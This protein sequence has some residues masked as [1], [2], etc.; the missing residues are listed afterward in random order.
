MSS[1]YDLSRLI[2]FAAS[3]ERIAPIM[4]TA[5]YTVATSR[6]TITIHNT[7]RLVIDGDVEVMGGQDRLH[8]QGRLL[9]GD[10]AAAAD[11]Q[12]GRGRR[13]RRQVEPRPL[14]GDPPP[15]QLALAEDDRPASQRISS[16]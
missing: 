7:N 4:R 9:P 16:R 1:A 15:V 6:R 3:D 11:R 10:A 12:P 2:T 5:E 13:A 14:L 8:L